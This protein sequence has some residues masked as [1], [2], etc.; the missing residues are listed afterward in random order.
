MRQVR[1]RRST[2]FWLSGC[3]TMPAGIRGALRRFW[4]P[5]SE[6]NFGIVHGLMFL[7]I[8]GRIARLLPF[9]ARLRPFRLIDL[10]VAN[11]GQFQPAF[12]LLAAC[13]LHDEMSIP[14]L[15]LAVL[16]GHGFQIKINLAVLVDLG[17]GFVQTDDQTFLPFNGCFAGSLESQEIN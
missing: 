16:V 2:V 9:L 10:T 14:I 12:S 15:V 4:F 8:S 6:G 5:W 1:C 17:A 3:D 13:G 7:L 11:N